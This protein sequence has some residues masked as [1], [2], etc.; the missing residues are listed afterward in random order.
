[1]LKGTLLYG[2]SG[3]VTSVINATAFGVL[4]E[5]LRSKAFDRILVM[6]NGISGFM[7]EKFLDMTDVDLKKLEILREL[8]G[9][10]FGS[11]RKNLKTDEE[12]EELFKVF[13]KYNV[14]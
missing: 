4:D 8:P 12:F 13:E 6:K 1:M 7:E 9:A 5:A 3:G 10:F 11:C 14:R 2:Q